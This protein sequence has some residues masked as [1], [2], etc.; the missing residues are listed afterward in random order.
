MLLFSIMKKVIS[1]RE[2]NPLRKFL[3][4]VIT[5]LVI[6]LLSLN[7]LKKLTIYDT[8][9]KK[10]YGFFSMI[11]YGLIEYPVETFTSFTKDYTSF[12]EQRSINDHLR[13]ELE[14]AA[15]WQVKEKEYKEEIETLKALNELDSVYSDYKLIPGR[16]ISRSFDSW[17]KVVTIDIGAKD[18]VEEG[19][20]VIV[21]NG[22][23]GRVIDVSENHSIVSLMISNSD[24][25]KISVTIHTDG[26][27][28]NGIIDSYDVETNLFKIELMKNEKSVAPNQDIVTSG[29]GGNFSRGLYFGKIE[30]IETV[31]TGIGLDIYAKSDINFQALDYIKVVKEP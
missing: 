1:M 23:L 8:T 31:A 15:L 13:L 29:L 7:M 28:V 16:V 4:V 19:D 12:W 26:K 6:A 14:D 9:E 3:S 30:S 24:F 22:I 21:P 5:V 18:G 11:R 20:A 25:T 2:N 10:V 27:N 17:N